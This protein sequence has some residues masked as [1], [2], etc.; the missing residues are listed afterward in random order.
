MNDLGE[1]S[2]QSLVTNLAR[3]DYI[4]SWPKLR[5]GRLHSKQNRDRTGNVAAKCTAEF[6]GWKTTVATTED[7]LGDRALLG[8]N[9]TSR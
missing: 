1:L 5:S 3:E 2:A 6:G 8:A 4:I 9:A 7:K